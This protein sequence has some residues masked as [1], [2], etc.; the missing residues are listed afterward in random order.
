[1]EKKYYEC[2]FIISAD[3]PE[4]KREELIKQ[5]TKMAGADTVVEKLGMRKF[6]TPINYKT[7]GFYVILNF[8]AEPTV[9]GKMTNLMNIT[10]GIVRHLF[11]AKDEEMLAQDVVRKQNRLRAIANRAENAN[12]AGGN[13]PTRN[14]D[15]R[16]GTNG[17]NVTNSTNDVEASRNAENVHKTTDDEP[18]KE[19]K[20]KK[21]GE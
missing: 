7:Q 16:N 5:F 13:E 21:K 20:T 15:E 11:I 6:A 3:T 4:T 19:T 17:T 1:M 10:D 12:N 8:K 18:V 2:M 9:P 14:G